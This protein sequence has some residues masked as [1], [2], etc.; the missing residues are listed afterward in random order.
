MCRRFNMQ[1]LQTWHLSCH[2]LPAPCWV[3]AKGRHGNS[4]RHGNGLRL[5]AAGWKAKKHESDREHTKDRRRT[6][7][8]KGDFELWHVL[9]RSDTTFWHNVLTQRSDTTF[10]HNVLTQRSDTTFWH[11]VLT[12]R[13][14]TTF[15]HNVLTQRSDT[16]WTPL[17]KLFE[18]H[19]GTFGSCSALDHF[20]TFSATVCL[21]QRKA[22]LQCVCAWRTVWAGCWVLPLKQCFF[23]STT[24]L[25]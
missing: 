1:W 25:P 3:L 7:T 2:S 15:W 5:E 21:S 8:E 9:K 6:R 22:L 24:V 23:L 4:E 20:H 18:N 16:F 10:W 11:N 13:S 17:C 14:D 12:Q 19:L